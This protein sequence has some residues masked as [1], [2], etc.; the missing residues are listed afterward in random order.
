MNQVVGTTWLIYV[1]RITV[2]QF[3]Y[4]QNVTLTFIE[5]RFI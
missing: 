1:G 4:S 3:S 2:F 5:N